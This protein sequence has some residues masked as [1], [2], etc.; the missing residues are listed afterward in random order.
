MSNN[1]VLTNVNVYDLKKIDRCFKNNELIKSYPFQKY[2]NTYLI[3]EPSN[4]KK[5]VWQILPKIN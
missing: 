1:V 5:F 4:F 2:Q 3:N